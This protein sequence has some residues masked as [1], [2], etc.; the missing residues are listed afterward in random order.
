MLRGPLFFRLPAAS[1]RKDTSSCQCGLFS[2]AQWARTVANRIYGV[3]AQDKDKAPEKAAAEAVKA[4]P[5]KAEPA[6]VE[7]P[8]VAGA[9]RPRAAR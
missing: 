6:K 7:V 8:R 3:G 1:S 9:P 2:M 5:A 4:E